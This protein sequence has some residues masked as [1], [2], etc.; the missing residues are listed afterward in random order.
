MGG[1]GTLSETTAGLAQISGAPDLGYIPMGTANDVAASLGLSENAAEAAQTIVTGRPMAMD[2]GLFNSGSFFT[3]IAAF[4][5]FTDV[6]YVTPQQSKQ[7]LGHFAYVLE[8]MKSLPKLP[9][10]HALVEYDKGEIEG[11][12]IFGGVTNSTSLA[13]LI[14]LDSSLVE[15][16]DGLFEVILVRTPKSIIDLQTAFSEFVNK[17][18]FGSQITILHSRSIRFHFPEPVAW[19]RDGENGG[20]HKDVHLENLQ[21]A[22]HIRVSPERFAEQ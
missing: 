1:D 4:G 16:G 17:Q 18:Y 13:G 19:T 9:T 5:A 10:T 20:E 3:Y 11:D 21:H 6:S 2:L 7:A 14:R 15:L 22:V 12:F 8:G